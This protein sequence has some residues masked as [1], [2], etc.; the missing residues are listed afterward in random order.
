[1]AEIRVGVERMI[2]RVRAAC[3]KIAARRL[4]NARIVRV[5]I[6]HAVT[7]LFPAETVDVCHIMFPDPWPK[8]RHHC[9]RTV[10]A[11]LLHGITRILTPSGVLRL[12]TDDA[13]YFEQMQQAAASVPQLA[14]VSND[15]EPP[16]PRSTFEM[17]FVN[18]GLPIHRLMLRKVSP[19]RCGDA[20]H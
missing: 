4:T 9:R 1:M 2:G 3:R 14:G 20:S 7:C 5:E 11:E 15:A 19:L 17:R 13:P 16:L 8:R 10:T 18:A 6:G 12:T